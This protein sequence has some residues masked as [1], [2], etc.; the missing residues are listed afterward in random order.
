M[1]CSCSVEVDCNG[2]APLIHKAK[3]VKARKDHQ[4]CECYKKIIPG[5]KY[6]YVKGKWN[7]GFAVHKTCLDCKSIR[8]TFFDSWV[9][10]E[11]WDCF[12]NDFGDIDSIVPESCIAELTPI[13]KNKVCDFIED[14]WEQFKLES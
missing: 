4:C 10:T 11:V 6:E 5:E 3:I 8:D 2:D 7:F 12:Q 13:A 1:E 14:G 9:Y